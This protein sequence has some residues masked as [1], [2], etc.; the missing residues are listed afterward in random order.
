MTAP[1]LRAA[2]SPET[3]AV[4][5][6]VEALRL[7]M[8]KGDRTQLEALTDGHLSYGHSSGR[9]QNQAQ[10]VDE[11]ASGRG[12]FTVIELKDQTIDVVGDTAIVRHLF[13]GEAVNEGK[14]EPVNLKV[15]QVWKREGNSWRL[16]ARQVI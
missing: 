10:F 6:A 2:D 11:I 1:A 15:L 12:R 5:H 14:A 3:S 13:T 4:A 16:L 9:L 7:A 8:L